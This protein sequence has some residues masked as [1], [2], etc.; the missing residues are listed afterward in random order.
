[1]QLTK[2]DQ[3]SSTASEA[4][5]KALSI[6]TNNTNSQQLSMAEQEAETSHLAKADTTT[7]VSHSDSA[8][9]F[10]RSK[11]HVINESSGSQRSRAGTESRASGNQRSESRADSRQESENFNRSN[12][13]TN[14]FQSVA[15]FVNNDLGGFDAFGMA[16][17]NANTAN[18]FTNSRRA[19]NR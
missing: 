7:T 4:T 2:V 17:F 14:S 12:N 18:V 13:A 11:S 8:D 6:F 10:N 5:A 19:S 3:E 15:S 9:V 16:G 1:N